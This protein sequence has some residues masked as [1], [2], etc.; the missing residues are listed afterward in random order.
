DFDEMRRRLK[1]SVDLQLKYEM[2]KQELVA[3][4][5]HD[6]R[7]PL[8]VIKG[9]VE[10]L[11]DGVANT[12]EKQQKYL[13]MIYKKACDMDFLVDNLFLFSKMDTDHY[14][15]HFQSTEI[16]G[17]LDEF[18]HQAKEEFLQKGLDISFEDHCVNDIDV[19]LDREEMG[20][21]LI[22]ILENSVKYKTEESG[23][24]KAMLKQADDNMVLTVA[25]DGPGV[26]MDDLSKLFTRF[27][28]GDPSRTNPHEGSGLGLAIAKHI[29]T[30]H[31]GAITARNHHGL[32]ITITLPIET[33]GN[34]YETNTD[35]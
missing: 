32:E 13:D 22:N 2:D 3:G 12:P 17:Y 31:E 25:D 35:Y 29:V 15:F 24:V 26:E 14:P 7:T 6:L 30:A 10:G 4:I 16:R 11:R 33:E 19:K 23:K 21:V 1:N 8:T 18:F 5:S 20:R 28:R 9:Y 27:Y 34:E